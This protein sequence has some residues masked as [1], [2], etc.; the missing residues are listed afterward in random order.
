MNELNHNNGKGDKERSPGWRQNY[1]AIAFPPA[2]GFARRGNRLVKAYGTGRK[3][4]FNFPEPA[5]KKCDCLPW[6]GATR[7]SGGCGCLSRVEGN[8]GWVC[9]RPKGHEGDHR[10][11]AT[12]DHNLFS[13]PRTFESNCQEISAHL[14]A[15]G[16]KL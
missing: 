9:T 8:N 1:D 2:E 5:T 6:L 7:D 15:N 4:V 16:A 11:C 13:W 3:A 10:A 12:R 14:L